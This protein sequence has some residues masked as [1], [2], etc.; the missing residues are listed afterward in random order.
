MRIIRES[1]EFS[2][3]GGAACVTIGMFDGVHLG[4]QAIL[5]RTIVDA[6]HLGAAA[7]AITFDQHP[8]RVV[9]PERAPALIYSLP[10]RLRALQTAGAD[11]VWLIHFDRDFSRQSGEEFMR[12]ML[13]DFESVR[14]LC[15][16]ADFTFGYRRSGTVALLKSLG[17][18]FGFDVHDLAAV[19][20]RGQPVSSTRIREAI[21]SGELGAASQMLG[22]TYSM[23]GEVLPGERLGRQLG[24]PTAN[25][26]IS[27]RVL[28][29]PG[30]YA[31]SV[32]W[33]GT[34]RKAV[35]NLGHRPTIEQAGGE[36]CFEVHVL[37]LN[38]DLYGQ[39]LEFQFG[40]RLR[41]EQKFGS[42]MELKERIATDVAQA[43]LL[44]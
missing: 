39:E 44:E 19:T 13:H 26:D 34:R 8:N 15:I 23:A 40:T 37:D 12:R 30:V 10:Q 6:R 25:L 29:P 18:E 17:S 3:K 5:Q 35:A 4:H 9:A 36:V 16:G 31:G 43:R 7:V 27:G 20:W 24:F 1:S 28:P 11:T 33:N 21:Q 41:G 42:V 2:P 14:S 38:D 32:H 22:R